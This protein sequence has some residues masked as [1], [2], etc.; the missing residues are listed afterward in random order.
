MDSSGNVILITGGSSGI[1]LAMAVR[2]LGMGNRVLITGRD[3]DKLDQVKKC[4]PEMEVFVCDLTDQGALEQLAVLVRHKYLELNILVNNAGVQ[5]NY[6]FLTGG[7][8]SGKIEYEIATNLLAPVKL[9]SLLLPLLLKN[10][11]SAI[12]NVSSALFLAPKKSASVYCATKAGIH[13]F[14]KTLRCQLAD[15]GIKVFEIIP[16]LVETPMTEGRGKS[17]ITTDQLVDEFFQ[18]FQRDK[19]ESYIGKSKYLK[20]LARLAPGF[21]EKLMQSA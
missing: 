15:T 19:F 12:V 10:V 1:R 9:T 18:D 20:L 8:L 4:Y 14:T 11:H 3:Q 13:S 21:A 2:F 6:E 17:K 16:P 7:Q 5:Y